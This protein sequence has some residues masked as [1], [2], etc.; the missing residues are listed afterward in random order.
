VW[1]ITSYFNPVGYRRR[2]SNYRIFRSNLA[3]PLVTVELSFDGRFELTSNDADILVQISGGAVLW[4]KERLLNIAIKSVPENAEENIAWLDC[5]VIFERPDWMHEAA[6]KL[7]EANVVQLFSD[8][9]DLRP[10]SC[11]SEYRALSPTGHG[12]VSAINKGGLKQLDAAVE[13]RTDIRQPFPTG[14]AWAA[15]RKI[16][17]NHG[18][19]DAMI[20]GGGDRAMIHALYGQFEVQRLHLNERRQQ[21]YLRW[22]RP[23]HRA[24][25]G[26]ID[27]VSGRIFHL[28]HGSFMNRDQAN[29]QRLLADF[30]FDP[31]LDL[32]IGP[33]GAWHWARPRPD[34]ED[35]LRKYFIRRAED[36]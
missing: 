6:Q 25:A 20:I 21:H 34:L 13:S 12:I 11:Q 4:Q 26:K 14:M 22:A 35:F 23:Y 3:V 33:N 1:A 36:E 5:D 28:W 18:L 31:D 15:R 19:Y 30:G 2:L 9:I 7:N 17:E 27:N 24:V 16:L 29:R 10:E 8:L 32:R